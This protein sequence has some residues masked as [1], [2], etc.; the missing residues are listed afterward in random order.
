M[1]KK[2]YYRVECECGKVFYRAS[3]CSVGI[4]FKFLCPVCGHL[5]PSKSYV[6]FQQESSTPQNF[7]DINEWVSM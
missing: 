1:I 6:L 4:T 5:Y 3:Y 7:Q 2:I